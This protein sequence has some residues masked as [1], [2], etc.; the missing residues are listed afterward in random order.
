MKNFT[1]TT[2]KKLEFNPFELKTK[3]ALVT[4]EA[5]GKTNTMTISWG[6][7]G[8]MW[9]KEVVFVVIRPQ[10]YT[11]EFVDESDTFSISFLNKKYKKELNYLG[12]VSGRDEDKIAKAGLTITHSKKTPY[13]EESE[14][15]FIVKKLYAQPTAAEFFIEK[16]L[17][18]KWY[19]ESDH[20]IL[21]IAEIDKIF[22]KS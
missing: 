3:W 6:A 15:V 8:I 22:V 16:D 17:I 2:T 18:K 10:R 11:K 1:E 4:A 12:D 9:N 14:L 13:F 19:P 7:F 20:H 5:N 21:Y